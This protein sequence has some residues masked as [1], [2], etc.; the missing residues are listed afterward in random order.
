MDKLPG[1]ASSAMSSAMNAMRNI[2]D[3]AKE[4]LKLS[5]NVSLPK[6]LNIDKG[7]SNV[8]LFTIYKMAS[9]ELKS[10][11]NISAEVLFRFL[12]F[13]NPS[14]VPFWVGHGMALVNLEKFDKAVEI[15]TKGSLANPDDPLPRTQLVNLY[16]KMDH[17]SEA[18]KELEELERIALGGQ[19]PDLQEEIL[20]IKIIQAKRQ[21]RLL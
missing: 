3:S 4:C 21:K 16:L 19:H 7:V 6:N 10:D 2:F 14:V 20:Q 5:K 13:L 11:N 17:I 18:K 8:S 1:I 12:T 9:N 15:F